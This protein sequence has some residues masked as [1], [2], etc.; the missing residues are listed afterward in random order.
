MKTDRLF[1]ILY[2]LLEKQTITAPEL[3]EKLEVSVRT[4]YRDVEALAVS[5][6]PVYTLPGKNGGISLMPGYTFDKSLLSDKEQEEVL[7]ALQSMKA[8][9]QEVSPLL[10]KLGTAF[11]KANR[12]WIEIDFSRWGF[13][14]T[15]TVKFECIKQGILNKQILEMRYSSSYGEETTRRVKPI[16]LVF[17]SSAWYIQAYCMKAQDF[18]TFKMNRIIS[19]ESTGESFCED[20]DC[21]KIPEV[22]GEEMPEQMIMMKLRVLPS[23]A[24][25]AYDE[26]NFGDIKKQADGSVIVSTAMPCGD[27]IYSYLLSFGTGVEIVEPVELREDIKKYLEKMI[28]Q[29]KT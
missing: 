22:D 14:K 19:L 1:Q 9:G 18:R 17:K 2:I 26:F 8:T 21:D 5:G 13:K 27:W 6:I 3:A 16:R 11:K 15:D 25:R 4:I 24:F 23:M 20:F 12:N 28:N 29:Y 10:N 7:F